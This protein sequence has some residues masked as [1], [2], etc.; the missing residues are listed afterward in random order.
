[1]F[2]DIIQKK[3]K[4][5]GIIFKNYP[6]NIYVSEKMKKWI[7]EMDKEIDKEILKSIKELK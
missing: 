6:K 3:I 1:M 2:D 5:Y 7:K 4:K